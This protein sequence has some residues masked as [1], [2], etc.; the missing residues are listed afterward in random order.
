[1]ADI[2]SAGMPLA[3]NPY[4]ITRPELIPAKRY[5][6]ETFYQAECEHLWPHVWQMACR[7]ETMP[8]VGDWVEYSNVGKSV[9]VVRTKDGV[10]AFQ[11]HCRHRGVP[12]AGGSGNAHGN[13]AKAG[14]I[15]PFHG[16]RWNMDGE[17][18]FVY[19]KDLFSDDLLDPSELALKPVRCETWGGCAFINHDEN[20]PSLK[21][22]L[23]PV[24]DR[25]DAH[26][27]SNVRSE[28]WFAT[29]LPANWKIAM[30]AFMEGYHVMMT[31]PQLQR[32]V[33]G[34]YNARYGNDTGGIGLPIDP[35]Q[36]VED[37]IRAQI[38]NLKLLGSGM[39]GMVHAK[40]IEIAEQLGPDN[41]DVQLPGT[42]AEAVP[43]WFGMVQAAV[44]RK[45]KERGENVPDLNAVAVSDPVN[46]VEYLF[47]HYF[48]LPFFTSY[49]SYRIRPTGPESCMFEI[50]SLTHFPEGEEPEPPMEPTVLPFDSQDFPMIP[51]QDYSNI[52]IQQKGLHSEGF[53][54][55]RLSKDVEGLISN[56][57]R[58]IDG[59]IAG[60]PSAKL[61]EAN[62]KL[63]GNFDGP[64]LDFGF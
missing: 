62:R 53:E 27:M 24:L 12:I 33:P 46:A 63:G 31:H 57:Q 7:L 21:E 8:N 51:R 44:T 49:A 2:N 47:P 40:E 17:N 22:C 61:A 50:W 52:P 42:V 60:E 35:D 11:N 55:M 36:S 48:L 5:Y 58:L 4:P 30:E 6:D 10:K 26:G 56:Y 25:L 32:S 64:I 3:G 23:G 38:E 34:L 13:C 14:F 1:M 9:L 43:M 16:W 45:L 29:E 20:A 37:N 41:P 59:Y 15:C 39:A 19:G 54:F 18:T 28:W